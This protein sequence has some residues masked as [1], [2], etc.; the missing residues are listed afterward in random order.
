MHARRFKRP[1]RSARSATTPRSRC[2]ASA[3]PRSADP[4][5]QLVPSRPLA[6]SP[7]RPPTLCSPDSFRT[8][9]ARL[10]AP[11]SLPPPQELLFKKL[12]GGEETD[13]VDT[14]EEGA[15]GEADGGPPDGDGAAAAPPP[16]PPL[17][18]Q[19]GES[20]ADFARR[21]FSAVFEDDVQRLLNMEARLG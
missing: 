21:V 7:S 2:T 17:K 15:D 5:E 9:P 18:Q 4:A 6:L 14:A 8:L 16:P 1:F 13:L 11:P 19:E 3:G 12:F 10:R 20:G